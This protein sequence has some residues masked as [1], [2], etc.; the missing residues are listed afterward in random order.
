VGTGQTTLLN[1][2]ALSGLT[3]AT[4][5]VKVILGV[6]YSHDRWTVNLRDT[7]YGTSQEIVSPDQTGNAVP[8]PATRLHIPVTSITDL[9]IGYRV[10]SNLKVSVGANNLFDH[11]PPVVPQLA[12]GKM[13]D[14]N[15]TLGEPYQFSPFGI[16]G[17]Y[18]YGKITLDF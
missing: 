18:Y 10:T 8:G 2:F 4:P 13:A 6:F 5:K 1:P 11:R 17:G 3:Q 15:N 14:G 9:D 16:N 7:V 12:N